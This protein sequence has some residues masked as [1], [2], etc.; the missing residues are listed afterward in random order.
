M[1]VSISTRSNRVRAHRRT[2]SLITA[3]LFLAVF[4]LL[5]LAAAPRHTV[6][7]QGGS[8][9]TAVDPGNGKV[10]DQI[11]VTGTNLGKTTVTGVYLSD[12]KDDFKA[13]IVDQDTGKIVL[14]V[15]Q[16]KAGSYN[17]SIL[18]GG[19]TGSLLIQPVRFSVEQ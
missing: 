17:I 4:A 7:A 8:K 13:T 14:K 2:S 6:L 1:P 3:A 12:D 10:N 16:V 11:T 15:P 18:V 9:V 19:P 5:A